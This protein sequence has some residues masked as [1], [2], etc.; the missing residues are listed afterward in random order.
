MQTGTYPG[1]ELELFAAAENWKTYVKSQLSP[2]LQGNVLEVG[3][4]IGSTTGYLCGPGKGRW[5]C[6]EPDPEMA[7]RLSRAASSGGLPARCEAVKGTI[8]DIPPGALFD[9]V[10]YIDVLEHIEDDAAELRAAAAMLSGGG[11]LIVLAPAHQFLY[12][13]FDRGVGHFRR[14]SLGDLARIAPPGLEALRLDYL[15]SAG[16]L[17]SLGNRLLLRSGMPTAGQIRF[18]DSFLVRISRR[19]DPLLAHR[20]GKSALAVWRRP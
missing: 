4:G 8:A 6:L 17:A 14:Y 20:L 1:G 13:A 10:I 2:Y 19:L 15:D 11:R 7:E 18:W 3:A 12:T 5:V 16:L 9:A